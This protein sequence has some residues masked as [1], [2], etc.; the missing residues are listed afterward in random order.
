MDV[1]WF[2]RE[3]AKPRPISVIPS[4]VLDVNSDLAIALKPHQVQALSFFFENFAV[5]KHKFG[6]LASKMGQGK[7]FAAIAFAAAV[8]KLHD[9]LPGLPLDTRNQMVSGSNVSHPYFARSTLWIV[10]NMQIAQLIKSIR[11]CSPN[12]TFEVYWER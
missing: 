5:K 8:R 10:P 1:P 4:D 7:T 2:L 11:T 3:L 6:I 9:N 12:D